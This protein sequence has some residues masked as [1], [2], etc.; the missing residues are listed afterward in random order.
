MPV[1]LLFGEAGALGFAF[2]PLCGI[3]ELP[4][5]LEVGPEE[6][7]FTSPET[8]EPELRTTLPDPDIRFGGYC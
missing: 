1:K 7:W 8:F 6:W 5:D 4:L 2:P 3:G